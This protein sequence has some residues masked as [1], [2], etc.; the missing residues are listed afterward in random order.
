[1]LTVT[2]HR[3]TINI[4]GKTAVNFRPRGGKKT[5]VVHALSLFSSSRVTTSGGRCQGEGEA[6]LPQGRAPMQSCC[7]H[8]L[9]HRAWALPRHRA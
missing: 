6:V 9:R 2:P 3:R 8:R 4:Q 1:M 5:E 7:R